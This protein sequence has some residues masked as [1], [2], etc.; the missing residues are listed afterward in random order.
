MRKRRVSL[1]VTKDETQGFGKEASD[2]QERYSMSD[3]SRLQGYRR[4]WYTCYGIFSAFKRSGCKFGF[5]LST[6]KSQYMA[7]VVIRLN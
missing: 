2:L 4:M 3:S 1:E 7:T 6:A 5:P